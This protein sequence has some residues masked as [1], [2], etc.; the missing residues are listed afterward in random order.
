MSDDRCVGSVRGSRVTGAGPLAQAGRIEGT[1]VSGT[2]AGT[3]S[4]NIP[5]ATGRKSVTFHD[6]FVYGP[7]IGVKYSSAL[8][9]PWIFTFV[10]TEGDGIAAPVTEITV[11]GEFTLLS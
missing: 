2:G 4:V 6:E 10:P 9:G 11:V 3:T 5:T 7:G 8:L 1:A